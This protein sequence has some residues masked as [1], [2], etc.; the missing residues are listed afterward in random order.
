MA[1]EKALLHLERYVDLQG[2]LNSEETAELMQ[3]FNV[4]YET[5][6]KEQ[7]IAL[8]LFIALAAV[9]AV[10]AVMKNKAARALEEKNAVLVKANL[11]KEKLLTIAKSNIPKE[12]TSEIL[13][14][15]SS[16]DAMPEVKLTKREMQ[17]AESLRRITTK[18]VE[19]KFPTAFFLCEVT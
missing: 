7:T 3:S 4:K 18:A 8:A 2:S 10:L 17:I 19:K 6:E 1:P 16:T 12:V 5:L 13:S 9:S 14:I 15:A 11:D